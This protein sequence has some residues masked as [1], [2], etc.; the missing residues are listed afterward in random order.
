[1]ADAAPSGLGDWDWLPVPQETTLPTATPTP[2]TAGRPENC[3]VGGGVRWA[4][5]GGGSGGPAGGGGPTPTYMAQN[6]P[7]V[8]LIIFDYTYVGEIFL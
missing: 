2:L 3:F 6:D 8:A 5:R 7:H 1:M 4:G